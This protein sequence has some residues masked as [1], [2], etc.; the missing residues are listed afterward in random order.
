[1]P[2][3]QF[4]QWLAN[5]RG[6]HAFQVKACA[7]RWLAQNAPGVKWERNAAC[8]KEALEGNSQETIPLQEPMN[9]DKL[10]QLSIKLAPWV[11]ASISEGSCEQYAKLAEEWLG[12]V[13]KCGFDLMLE[14]DPE[15][16]E[17]NP[18]PS[19]WPVASYP[20]PG[21]PGFLGETSKAPPQDLCS[22]EGEALPDAI[23]EQDERLQRAIAEDWLVKYVEPGDEPGSCVTTLRRCSEAIAMAR[24]WGQAEVAKRPELASQVAHMTDADH[25]EEYIVINWANLVRPEDEEYELSLQRHQQGLLDALYDPCTCR[26][27]GIGVNPEPSGLCPICDTQLR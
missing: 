11:S 14:T 6:K 4:I 19:G 8:E 23:R 16:L 13:D 25:L 15:F 12:E 22:H 7:M 24:E 27:C 17:P 3:I 10:L 18:Q 20:A 5:T 2:P 9:T 21:D 26:G 1:M